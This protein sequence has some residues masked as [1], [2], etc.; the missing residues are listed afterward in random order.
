MD[1][2]NG[3]VVGGMIGLPAGMILGWFTNALITSLAA[4]V[5]MG[6]LAGAAIA[7]MRKRRN[8]RG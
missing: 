4:G 1:L 8:L 3:I 2:K 6:M 7:V 5:V